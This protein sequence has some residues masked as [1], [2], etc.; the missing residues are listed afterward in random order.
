MVHKRLYDQQPKTIYIFQYY[1]ELVPLHLLHA[2]QTSVKVRAGGN[3]MASKAMVIPVFEGEK[4][5]HLDSNNLRI[6]Y[7]MASTS[8]SPYL[9]TSKRFSSDFFKSTSIQSI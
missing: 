8:G 1:P 9:G 7:R 3:G 4:W 6:C 2:T 5:R